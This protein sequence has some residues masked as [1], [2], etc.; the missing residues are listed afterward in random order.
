[1]RKRLRDK[2]SEALPSEQ[3]NEVYNSFDIVGDIAIIKHKNIQNAEVVAKQIMAVHRNIKTVL[4]PITRITGD[5]RVRELKLLVGENKTNTCHKE[6]GCTFKVDVEKCYFSPRLSYEHS[7]IAGLVKPGEIVVNMFAG[8]GCFSI[9]MSKIQRRTKVYSIDINPIAVKCMEENVIVNSVQGQ[10]FPLLGDAK[11][12]IQTKLHGIADRVLMPLPEK[13]LEYLRYAL[14]A[15][16]KTG[17]W[18]HFYDFQHAKGNE[19]PVDKT[20]VTVAEKLDSL[21]AR[22]K[23]VNSRVIRSTGPNWYQIVID[24]HVTMLP[25]KF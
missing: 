18:I 4:T 5:F 2:L 23:F 15:L 20:K 24:I 16:K 13:S 6:S 1:L 14:S 17:G 9:I 19:D 11:D 21:G 3:L 10:V 8:I 12:I 7:R 22:Y 25:S